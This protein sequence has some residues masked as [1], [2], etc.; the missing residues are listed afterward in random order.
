MTDGRPQF[1][2]ICF[3]WGIVGQT[4]RWT[5]TGI[6][7]K[8]CV[9]VKRAIVQRQNEGDWFGGGSGKKHM[10]VMVGRKLNIHT[11]YCNC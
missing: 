4:H 1:T 3:S 11:V 5:L 8:S 6:S 9:G 10:G 2:I 7:G